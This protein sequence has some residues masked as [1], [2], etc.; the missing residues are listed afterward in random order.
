MKT[1]GNIP[2]PIKRVIKV[3]ND[4]DIIDMIL[5]LK[6]DGTGNILRQINKEDI[7]SLIL[8]W[9]D[10]LNTSALLMQH[11]PH[12]WKIYE[13]HKFLMFIGKRPESILR[14]FTDEQLRMRSVAQPVEVNALKI[15]IK[16]MT[17]QVEVFKQRTE[18]NQRQQMYY[19][20]MSHT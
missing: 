15:I 6:V 17:A 4:N 5:D 10:T 12:T 7:N 13:D 11:P 16:F 9:S 1:I 19:N 20:N 8:F 2:L 14:Y 18:N 3:G